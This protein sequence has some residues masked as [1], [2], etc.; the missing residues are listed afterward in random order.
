[1]VIEK[2]A[3]DTPPSVKG[4]NGRLNYHAE[5]DEKLLEFCGVYLSVN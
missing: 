2:V 5:C 1:M 3:K 4:S